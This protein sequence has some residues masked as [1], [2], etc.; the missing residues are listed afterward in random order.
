M[1]FFKPTAIF[2]LLAI[3]S[4]GEK[5]SSKDD[6]KLDE[7]SLSPLDQKI[8]NGKKVYEKTCLACHQ[9]DGK[10]VEGAF[11]PLVSSDYFA[12]DKMLVVKNIVHGL[13]GEI[14]VNGKKYNAEMPKQVLTEQ[15]VSDVA[16]YVL[17]SF[18]NKGG[19]ISIEEVQSIIK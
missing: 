4:C 8:S 11:P 15:E 2:L 10:G 13:K 12:N 14:T 9:V 18:N 7:S 16:T 5:K 3:V 6:F 1:N 17:N 19:E